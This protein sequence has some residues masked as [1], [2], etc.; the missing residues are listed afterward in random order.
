[1]ATSCSLIISTYNWP[2][3]LQLCLQ[4]VLQ[5]SVLPAEII[6]ADDGSTEET[7][8]LI[9]HMATQ[10]PV[11]LLHVWQPD[12]GFQLS[13]IRNRAI[14]K[15]A[16]PYIIQIDGDLLL[17]QHFIKDHFHIQEPGYFVSG[18]RVLLS[19]ET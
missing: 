2:S 9:D 16:M 17:H 5:Q 4:S 12:E 13:K 8:T 14:A 1:M 6:I 10:C 18:S 15:A 11:P 3:A 7:K 19:P